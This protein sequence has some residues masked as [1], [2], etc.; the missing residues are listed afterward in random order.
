LANRSEQID[1]LMAEAPTALVA[2]GAAGGGPNGTLE[3]RA[4]IGELVLG[5]DLPSVLGNLTPVQLQQLLALLTGGAGLSLPTG[6]LGGAAAGSGAAATPNLVPGL[7]SVIDNLSGMLA[8][9]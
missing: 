8:V 1:H 6:A 7:D 4:D 5:L 3:A 9:N 2:L